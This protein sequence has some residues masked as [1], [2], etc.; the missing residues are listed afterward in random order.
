MP[1]INEVRRILKI[2]ADPAVHQALDAARDIGTLSAIIRVAKILEPVGP[3]TGGPSLVTVETRLHELLQRVEALTQTVTQLSARV[4]AAIPPAPPIG[5]P[6]SGPSSTAS[7]VVLISG[8][9]NKIGVIKAVRALTNLGLK[10]A[11]DVVDATSLRP[12]T[13]L[14]DVFHDVAERAV[15]LLREAGGTASVELVR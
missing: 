12:Q 7:N 2:Q 6:F 10:E 5:Q 4:H 9:M 3:P 14:A 13:V 15:A 11:K 8:G 1:T